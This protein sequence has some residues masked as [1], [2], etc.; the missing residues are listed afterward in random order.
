MAKRVSIPNKPGERA[1]SP[2]QRLPGAAVSRGRRRCRAV[3]RGAECGRSARWTRQQE[4]GEIDQEH[5]LDVD[6]GDQK[7]GGQRRY[8]GSGCIGKL[9]QPPD[10]AE[11]LLG[12]EQRGDGQV[13]GPLKGAQRRGDGITDVDVPY[14][15]TPGG[16]QR[17]KGQRDEGR[18]A[19]AQNNT[20]RRSQRS[21]RAPAN[22]S[23]IR[24]GRLAATNE[25]ASWVA[26]PVRL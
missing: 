25:S 7:A 19:V 24:L 9:H 12:H 17:P 8:N 6:H 11:L 10:A 3:R 15:Q 18:T 21:T 5:A 4:G 22:G 20:R 13:G 14:L 1:D 23:S 26:A 16:Q 2:S